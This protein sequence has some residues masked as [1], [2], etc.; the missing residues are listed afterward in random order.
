M[1]DKVSTAIKEAS[2]D[3]NTNNVFSQAGVRPK[4]TKNRKKTKRKAQH[5]FEL[6]D[7]IR[8]TLQY[9]CVITPPPRGCANL[10]VSSLVDVSPCMYLH[11]YTPPSWR[12]GK[13]KKQKKHATKR[14]THRIASPPPLCEAQDSHD[15]VVAAEVLLEHQELAPGGRAAAV[16]VVGGGNDHV[17]PVQRRVGLLVRYRSIRVSA[18]AKEGRKEGS[19]AK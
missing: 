3:T 18:Q 8:D 2:T 12:K 14:C 16:D 13:K 6:E 5:N 11:V 4:T 7:V 9:R 15:V 19:K 17:V 1:F 10:N